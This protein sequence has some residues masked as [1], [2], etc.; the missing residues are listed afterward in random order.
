M[1]AHM[2]S[3]VMNV[4]QEVHLRNKNQENLYKLKW[5]D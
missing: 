2:G 3:V 5:E 4:H 1:S